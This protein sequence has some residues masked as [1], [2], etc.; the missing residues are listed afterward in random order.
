LSD[1]YS[2]QI[3]IFRKVAKLRNVCP[4]LC[5]KTPHNSAASGVCQ[6]SVFY[7]VRLRMSCGDNAA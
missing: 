6:I 1:A 3:E 5:T 4:K 7:F 2:Q